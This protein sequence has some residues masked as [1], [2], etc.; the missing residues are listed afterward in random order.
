MCEHS[1]DHGNFLTLLFAIHHATDNQIIDDIVVRTMV[2]L[3]NVPIATLR[4][5]ETSRFTSIVAEL[6]ESV[7]SSDSVEKE[8]AKERREKEAIEEEQDSESAEQQDI[9]DERHPAMVML[10][11]L[12]NNKLLGQVLRNQYG[13]LPKR[14]IEEIV[15][16]ITD[17]SFRIINLVLKDEDEIEEFARHVHARWPDADFEEVQK[18]IR[19]FSFVWTMIQI[20]QAV[21]AV[22]V[23]GIRDA[24]AEVVTR[25]RTPAYEIFGYFYDLDSGETLTRKVRDK[26]A[27]L[28]TPDQDDFV[29]R[30][31]SIRTQWYMN[32]HHSK[33]NIEQSICSVLGI[34]YRPRLKSAE[35]NII[36]A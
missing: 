6:P 19:L 21:H 13:K 3:E 8:R 23:P 7:L 34:P 29:K 20:E 28:H 35:A 4:E 11:I 15:E 16:T 27:D 17:S 36:P 32:T 18:L 5:D 26:L 24:I 33:T 30:V 10:R 14:Q 2:E 22:S 31:L 25:N 12:K 9:G 1:Y